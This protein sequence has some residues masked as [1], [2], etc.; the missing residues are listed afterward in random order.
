M[1]KS[2]FIF[3]QKSPNFSKMLK[4]QQKCEP[5]WQVK[6]TNLV[7]QFLERPIPKCSSEFHYKTQKIS[8]PGGL[9]RAV[10][11]QNELFLI[12]ILNLKDLWITSQNGRVATQ[13]LTIL[14]VVGSNPTGG[15]FF[16]RILKIFC[17]FCGQLFAFFCIIFFFFKL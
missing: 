16:L 15:N 12:H 4:F 5:C 6:Y 13:P 7:S 17:I 1:L 11:I 8:F 9:P 14:M 3:Q 10:K 2:F